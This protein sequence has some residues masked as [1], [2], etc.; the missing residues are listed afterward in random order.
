MPRPYK[1]PL[2]RILRFPAKSDPV[3]NHVGNRFRLPPQERRG[4]SCRIAISY[5]KDVRSATIIHARDRRGLETSVTSPLGAKPRLENLIYRKSNPPLERRGAR[6][7]TQQSHPIA[8]HGRLT[9]RLS[10]PN[11]YF[12]AY[13][14]LMDELRDYRFYAEICSIPPHWPLIIFGNVYRKFLIHRHF[15]NP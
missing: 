8:S 4:E 9:E 6:E 13:E 15:G 3:G 1:Q 14:I 12:P 7:P 11:R 5:R 10:R 2:I